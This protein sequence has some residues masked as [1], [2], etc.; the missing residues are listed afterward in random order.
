MY[1]PKC[2]T[3]NPDDAKV[4]SSCS[5]ELRKTSATAKDVIPKMSGLAL[6]SFILGLISVLFFPLGLIAMILGIAGIIVIEK[7]GGRLTGRVFAILGIVVPVLVFCLIAVLMMALV[8]GLNRVKKQAESIR[9]QA[10][11]RQWGVIFVMYTQDNNGKFQ[12]G[13]GEGFTCHWMNALRPY[14]RNDYELRCCPK[15]TKPL[16][17]EYG[18]TAARR[19]VFLAWGIFKGEGFAP[20]GDWGS[21]GINGWVENPPP[22][23]KTFYQLNFETANNWRTP[24]VKGANR[25]PVF[26]DAVHYSVLPRHTDSPPQTQDAGG[27][28]SRP[29]MGRVC[30]NR[31]QGNVN[32]LFMDWSVRKVALKEL[33]TLKWHRAYDTQGPWT[34]DGGMLPSDWP[35]W[36]RNLR[37]Y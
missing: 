31:H 19:D 16:I 27:G 17:D 25:I 11:L 20:E 28:F 36:M 37:D 10:N 18:Q 29:E 4:C 14:Y 24:N 33:W 7:S 2:G 3:Q 8:P 30:I 32:S 26:M 5:S 9:C 22:E 6:A 15:A 35:E 34:R 1:C 13:V 21:Y 23:H 12:A